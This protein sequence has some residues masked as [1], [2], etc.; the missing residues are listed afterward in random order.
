MSDKYEL[1]VPFLED[2]PL[3]ALGCQFGMDVAKP[4]IEHQDLIEGYFSVKIEEQIRIACHRMGYNIVD[5]RIHDEFWVWIS[6]RK[7]SQ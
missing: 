6:M 3:F 1:V 5:Y 4:M 2:N 7:V